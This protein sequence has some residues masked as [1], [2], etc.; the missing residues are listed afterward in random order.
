MLLKLGV[1][2]SRLNPEIR[3]A[4][5]TIELASHHYT[6]EPVI[7]STYEGNHMPSSYHYGNDAI[8]L[9]LPSRGIKALIGRLKDA[10]PQYFDVVLET[11]HIHI[12]FDRNKYNKQFKKR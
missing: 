9:R 8:D 2:I 6:F 12:E 10:L 5:S 1:D 7:T 3:G 4:L 11:S